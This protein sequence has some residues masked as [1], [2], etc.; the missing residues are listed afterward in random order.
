MNKLAAM[1]LSLR[2]IQMSTLSLNSF[3]EERCSPTW[4][5]STDLRKV[6]I[7]LQ[8]IYLWFVSDCWVVKISRLQYP[9]G[10][11]EVYGRFVPRRFVP[12]S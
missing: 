10:E 3:L 5:K 2:T 9:S 8:F 11:L 1:F 7:I 12:L 6:Y 4:E